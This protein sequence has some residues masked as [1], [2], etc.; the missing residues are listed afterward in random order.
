M[1][2]RSNKIYPPCCQKHSLQHSWHNLGWFW[3]ALLTTFFRLGQILIGKQYSSSVVLQT[4]PNHNFRLYHHALQEI[5]MHNFLMMDIR[6]QK[7]GLRQSLVTSADNINTT[8]MLLLQAGLNKAVYAIEDFKSPNFVQKLFFV[9]RTSRK[10]KVSYICRK[11]WLAYL[12]LSKF[13]CK[14]IYHYSKEKKV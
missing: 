2:G 13:G 10:V 8:M 6:N 3:L 12:I 1:T 11:S 5:H 14:D 7:R 9:S 4:S